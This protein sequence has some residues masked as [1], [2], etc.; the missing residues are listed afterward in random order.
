MTCQDMRNLRFRFE[1]SLYVDSVL[2]HFEKM[3]NQGSFP[4]F[5]PPPNIHEKVLFQVTGENQLS[6]II[7]LY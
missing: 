2:A 3:K 4:F 5:P 1:N 6:V 7:N